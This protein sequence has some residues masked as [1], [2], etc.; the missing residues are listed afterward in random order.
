M[1][2]ADKGDCIIT[3]NGYYIEMLICTIIGIIWYFSVRNTLK[4]F[5]TKNPSHWLVKV[6]RAVTGNE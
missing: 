6:K 4:T 2:K 1:C 5:Q 3:V